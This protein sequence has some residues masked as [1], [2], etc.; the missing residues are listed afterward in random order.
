ML[1]AASSPI[2]G[3][4]CCSTCSFILFWL[5]TNHVEHGA[6]EQLLVFAESVL[7][8]GEVGDS[9]IKLMSSHAVVK[10][11]HTLVIL[12]LLLELKLS[13][14]LHEL[15]ELMWDASTQ[16]SQRSIDLLLLDIVIFLVLAATWES[17][18]W[19]GALD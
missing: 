12:W 8:P 10:E 16:L 17:L 6:L 14:V 18:P 2:P 11:P 13:A 5:L 9:W 4:C 1:V 7:L 19:Q 3:S 15:L